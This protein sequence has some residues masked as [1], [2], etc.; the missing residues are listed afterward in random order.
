[1]LFFIAVTTIATSKAVAQNLTKE[2]IQKALDEAYAKFKDLKKEKMLII[3]R[4]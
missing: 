2:N 4:N 1:M 3:L